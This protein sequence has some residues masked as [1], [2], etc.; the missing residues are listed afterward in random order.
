MT[1]QPAR[2]DDLTL[3]LCTP[4]DCWK[5]K[6]PQQ[7]FANIKTRKQDFL[8]MVE[9]HLVMLIDN[10]LQFGS[11]TREMWQKTPLHVIPQWLRNM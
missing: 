2:S 7:T 5:V 3:D 11:T 10:I 8:S 1:G 9:N 6:T 4:L